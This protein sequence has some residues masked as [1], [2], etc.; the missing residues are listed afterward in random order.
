MTDCSIVNNLGRN[1]REYQDRSDASA[2]S[3]D[4]LRFPQSC[5]VIMMILPLNAAVW[6]ERLENLANYLSV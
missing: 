2:R 3:G 4:D 1:S 5:R 6:M